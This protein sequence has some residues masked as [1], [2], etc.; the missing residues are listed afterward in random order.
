VRPNDELEFAGALARLMDS[1]EQ[2]REMGAL[3]RRRV[4]GDLSWSSS[5]KSLLRAYAALTSPD[6]RAASFR[7]HS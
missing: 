4:E 5:A 3:G 2:R 6:R 7:A 1:P